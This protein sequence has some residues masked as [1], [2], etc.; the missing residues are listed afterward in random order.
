MRISSPKRRSTKPRPTDAPVDLAALPPHLREMVRGL[1]E[2]PAGLMEVHEAYEVGDLLFT[3]SYDPQS[4][5]ILAGQTVAD[6]RRASFSHVAMCFAPAL[7][8]DAIPKD[9]EQEGGARVRPVEKYADCQFH[10]YPQHG[11]CAMRLSLSDAQKERFHKAILYYLGQAYNFRFLLKPHRTSGKAFCS[12]FVIQVL[13]GAG[14]TLK[15]I[16]DAHK[17]TPS[18]IFRAAR[19]SGAID[20][21]HLYRDVADRIESDPRLRDALAQDGVRAA[22]LSLAENQLALSSEAQSAYEEG[23]KVSTVLSDSARQSEQLSIRILHNA[24]SAW[25]PDPTVQPPINQWDEMRKAIVA[26]RQVL[27]GSV[28]GETPMNWET[29]NWRSEHMTSF[30]VGDPTPHL[31]TLVRVAILLSDTT[32]KQRDKLDASR[33]S[34]G[35]ITAA[36]AHMPMDGLPMVQ[37]LMNDNRDRLMPLFENFEN[38]A[39]VLDQPWPDRPTR[40]PPKIAAHAKSLQDKL[41]QLEANL[42]G[43]WIAWQSLLDEYRGL[44]SAVG[45]RVNATTSR[46][47]ETPTS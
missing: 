28:R 18:A 2:I 19:A 47:K 30:E 26:I 34:V 15:G 42:Q 1:P 22:A 46:L 5:A 4:L 45:N 17:T 32:K 25:H 39:G 24:T 12:Q 20:V 31:R 43:L 36:V 23:R 8:V 38:L 40:Y 16:T 21:S 11:F 3:A 35:W 13:T 10:H 9:K 44:D 27:A 33:A 7:L 29:G 41:G 6:R 14:V 37:S